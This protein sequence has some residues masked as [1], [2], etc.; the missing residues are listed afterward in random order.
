[1]TSGKMN[2]RVVV[3]GM[4]CVTPFGYGIEKSWGALRQACSAPAPISRFD[5]SGYRTTIAA[6]VDDNHALD[7]ASG[8]DL[9]LVSRNTRFSLATVADLVH[10]QD[11]SAMTQRSMGVC[12]GSGLGGMYFTEEAIAALHRN[13]SRGISPLTVPFVDP[14]AIVS[15]VAI[16][17]KLTGPQ[18]TI[19]TACSSSAHAIGVAADM[20]RSGRCDAV[21]T[22]GVE[23]T[24]SP[25]VFSGFDRLRAMTTRNHTPAVACR[26][27]SDD[28]D[29]FVMGEGA[30][31]LLLEAESSAIKRGARIHA[32][33][34]GYGASGGAYHPVA[35]L[36]DGADLVAAMKAA[37]VDAGVAPDEIDLINPHGTGTR[38]NDDAELLALRTVFGQ[39]LDRI[40]VTPTKQLS[41][42]LLGASAALESLHVIKSIEESFVTPIRY[43][44]R[45]SGLNIL[46]GSGLRKEIRIAMKNSFGFGNN[47]VSLIF[48]AYR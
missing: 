47:N 34:L 14:N 18:L 8:F 37:L 33:L 29:G 24:M 13:G 46:V 11:L 32:E 22:G 5:T 10:E 16:Q 21:L 31:M 28:R 40:H 35:P 38:L 19:S 39:S 4:G 20:I 2:R 3:T 6:E 42:H 45:S 43:A 7:S 41:G 36:P 26:P 27:F 9:K 15:R 30:A 1:M 48:G 23:A 44:D 12:L 17:W 25:L